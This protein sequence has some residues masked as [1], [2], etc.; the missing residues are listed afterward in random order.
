MEKKK[1]PSMNC[2]TIIQMTLLLIAWETCML[3][4]KQELEPCMEQLTGSGLKKD[5]LLS[6]YFFNLSTDTE[7][8]IKARLDKLQA[9]IKIARGNINNHRYVYG[10]HSSG[11]KRRLTKESFD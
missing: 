8:L 4:K 1:S 3:V 9:G 10:N 6:L 11:R 2:K 7:H 5:C